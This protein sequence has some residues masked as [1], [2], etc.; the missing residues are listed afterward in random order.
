MRTSLALL[1]MAALAGCAHRPTATP[2]P[3]PPPA[4]SAP[5]TSDFA[6]TLRQ[7]NTAVANGQL[8]DAN[9]LYVG[10][11]DA[12]DASR[13]AVINAAT[14]LYRTA[15]YADAARAFAKLGAFARGEEDLRYYNAV[16]LYETGRFAEA[17]HEL[18]CAL[19]YIRMTADVDRYRAKIE[20]K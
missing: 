7:A 17:K 10:V 5:A 13:D 15:D 8:A 11:A 2:E 6:D 12:P 3:P 16:S 1:M 4:P 20:S 19:P 9:R 14:G 18:A